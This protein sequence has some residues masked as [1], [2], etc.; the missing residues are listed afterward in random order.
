MGVVWKAHDTT[1][2]RDVAVKFLPDVFAGDAERLGRFEREAK[3][4]ASL[5]HPN[6]AALYGLHAAGGTRFLSMELV[7]GEDL[8]SRLARADGLPVEEALPIAR[9]VAEALEAAHESGIVHRDLKPANIKVTDDGRVKVLDFG[10]ARV[11]E[12]ET[13]SGDLSLSPTITQRATQAGVIMGTAAYMSPEQARGRSVDRRADIWAFGVVLYELLTGRRLFDGETVSDT[14]AAVLRSDPDWSALPG[15]TPPA[16]RRLLRRCLQRDPRRRLRD[17]GDARVEIEEALAG[18][19]GG[20]SGIA[21]GWD[22]RPEEMAAGTAAAAGATRADARPPAARLAM[23]ALAA[24]ALAGGGAFVAA[25]MLAPVAAPPP[26]RKFEITVE[27]LDIVGGRPPVISPDGSSLLYYADGKLWLRRLGDLKAREVAGG[28]RSSNAF[29]SSDGAM[30]GFLRD[31][32]VWKVALAGGESAALAS[33]PGAIVGGAGGAWRPDGSVVLSTGTGPAYEI[34]ARGGDPHVLMEPIKGEETDFHEPHLLPDGRGLVFVVHRSEG[35]DTIGA[36][37]DGK[38]KVLLRIKEQRF[39]RPQYA[40]SGHLI[41]E[42][43]GGSG[44]GIW[45]APF[46]LSTMEIT[47]DPFLVVSEGTYPSVAGDG[48]LA[49]FAGV[50]GRELIVSVDRS[51]KVATF[52]QPQAGMIQP[53]VSPDGGRVAVSAEESGNRDIW[54]HDLARG[55]RTRLTFDPATELTPTWMPDGKRILFARIEGKGSF[56]YLVPADGTGAPEMITQGYAPTVSSDGGLLAYNLGNQGLADVLFLRLDGDRTPS[57]RVATPHAELWPRIS[58][59]GRYLAYSSNES[60]RFEIYIRRFPTGEGR[61][62]VSAEGGSRPRWSA[63]GDELFFSAGDDILAVEVQTSPTI[64]LGSP[65]KILSG[66]PLNLASINEFDIMPDGGHIIGL[67][68]EAGA[69]TPRITLVQSWAREFEP[70]R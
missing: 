38:R 11:F 30:V 59:D 5:N 51:G 70:A 40:L 60:G 49:Y 22:L 57:P 65:R 21:S 1:L 61:W 53:A 15:A 33:L 13:R 9:Q 66:R 67:Q 14:I 55:T 24:T 2:G 7:P 35:T 54:I 18:G 36:L 52:G 34:P 25:R 47:G 23:V 31:G 27:N 46:S 43:F 44:A 32:K 3:L 17:I 41:Y 62:Q 68:R 26:L 37:V 69:V 20:A 42:R 63:R 45:A 10:L 64:R 12:A 28:E 39:A 6:I 48:T 56:L 29:W 8:A 19:P 16:V 50:G 4:L 58:P